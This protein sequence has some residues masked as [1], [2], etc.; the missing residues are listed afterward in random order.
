MGR[1][2][3]PRQKLKEWGERCGSGIEKKGVFGSG[4]VSLHDSN[5]IKKEKKMDFYFIINIGQHFQIFCL[6]LSS[7]FAIIFSFKVLYLY[8][9]INTIG[10]YR[11]R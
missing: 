1:S 5:S 3:S 9:K 8:T 4:R 7:T 6:L 11:L 10:L 2:V